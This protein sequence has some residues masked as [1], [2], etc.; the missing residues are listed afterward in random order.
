LEFFFL[1]FRLLKKDI[2]VHGLWVA[3]LIEILNEEVE[4]IVGGSS[5]LDVE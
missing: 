5:F 2:V 1:S 4:V 3:V